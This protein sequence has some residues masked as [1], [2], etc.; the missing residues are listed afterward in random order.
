MSSFDRTGDEPGGTRELPGGGTQAGA[1]GGPAWGG[2]TAGAGGGPAWGGGTPAGPGGPAKRPGGGRWRLALALLLT[3][4]L[5]GTVGAVVVAAQGGAE[6]TRAAVTVTGTPAPAAATTG[7]V[8][9]AL[10]KIMPA[11]VTITTVDG[12]A[13]RGGQRGGAGTGIIVAAN[14]EVVTNAH[15]VE[16]ASSIRV[17]IPGRS[18]T[19]TARVVGSDA[20]ADLALLRLDGVS[21]LPVATFA[22]DSTVHVGDPVL[23]VGNAEGYGGTPTVTEGIVSAVDRNLPAGSGAS[24]TLRGL[25]QT[26]AAINPGN[27]GGALV[28]TAGRVIGVTTAVAGGQ[29]GAPAEN[30]GF[31]IRS[32]AVVKALPDLRAGRNVAGGSRS[33]PTAFLG[34][35]LSDTGGTGALVG[36]VEPGSPAASAGLQAG[37]VITT[38][39]GTSINS[40]ADLQSVIARHKPGDRISLSWRPGGQGQAKTGTVTLARRPTS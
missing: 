11:V 23:A 18:G 12:S 19:V 7:D 15:V 16:G 4:V 10:A 21:G 14:G 30:I 38:A 2:G 13:F 39:D 1:G 28:D 17:Q 33:N 9:T 20:G 29:R 35:Q 22:A 31:A 27:S 3:A 34:V 37:D 26:D 8:R 36:A 25:L 5:A 40:A 32:D 24:G 6:P